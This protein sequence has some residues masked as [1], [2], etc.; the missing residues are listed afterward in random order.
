MNRLAGLSFALIVFLGPLAVPVA[1][2]MALAAQRQSARLG[3]AGAGLAK[4][5]VFIG[6]AYFALT[7]VVIALRIVLGS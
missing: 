5:T 2:P 3:Q 1:V 7:V 4:S 6:C